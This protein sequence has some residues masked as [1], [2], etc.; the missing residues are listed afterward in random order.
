MNKKIL[1]VCFLGLFLL[2]NVQNALALGITPGRT[3]INFEPGLHQEVSFSII[4]SGHKDMSVVFMIRGE[5]NESVTLN[6]LYAEFNASEESKSFTYAVDLPQR[7]ETPGKHEIEIVAVEMP[8]DLEEIGMV[9]G[10]TLSVVTQLYIYVPYPNKYVEADVNVVESGGEITFLIPVVSRGKLDI[11][12]MEAKIDVYSWSDEKVTSL[13][14]NSDSLLSLERKELVAKW[15]PEVAPGKYKA[16]VNVVYDEDVSTIEKEFNVGE[17]F[18]EIRELVVK[19][20]QLG[21]IAKFSALVENKWSNDLKDVYLN[22]IVYNNEGETMADFKSP[23]YDI[24]SLSQEE[25]IAYWDTGGV[26]KGT[27]DGKLILRYGEK[28]TER[29]IQLKISDDKIEIIGITGNVVVRGSKFNL[30][31]ILLIG[32]GVLIAVNIVW[33]VIIRKLLKKR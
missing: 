24:G 33:F 8:K 1:L 32:V 25:M 9:V 21:E 2:A 13:V 17:M 28:A 26:H 23:T 7:I 5:M 15:K 4:N 19:D 22:I 10:A 31:N 3:T 18:L 6:Q 11:V 29:N 27:Y 30:T 14:S 12:N 16:V 20:F